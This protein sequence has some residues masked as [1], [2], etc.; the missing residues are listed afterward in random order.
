MP[1]ETPGS[2]ARRR[3]YS[4]SKWNEGYR[5]EPH[6]SDWAG[7]Y[8]PGQGRPRPEGDTEVRLQMRVGERRNARRRRRERSRPPSLTLT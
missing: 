3:S 2:P 4:P 6:T 5:L 7:K 1:H 8:A